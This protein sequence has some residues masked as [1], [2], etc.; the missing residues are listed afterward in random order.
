MFVWD[1]RNEVPLT[2]NKIIKKTNCIGFSS[3]ADYFVTVG[4]KTV[5]YWHF[6]PSGKPQVTRGSESAEFK[7]MASRS[8]ILSEM[9][10]KNFI[11][12]IVNSG[13]V[14]TLT[15]DGQL[16]IFTS[17]RTLDRWMDLQVAGAFSLS[18]SDNVLAC[19]CTEGVVRLFHADSLKYITSLPRPPPL[20]E[21]P[22]QSVPALNATTSFAD[23]VSVVLFNERLLTLY[24]DQSMLVWD[25]SQLGQIT[26]ARAFLHHSAAINDLKILPSSS[27][28]STQ[29]ITGSADKTLRLWSVCHTVPST[30]ET[31]GSVYSHDLSRIIYLSP[32]HEHFKARPGDCSSGGSVKCIS[33]SADGKSVASGDRA[34]MLRVHDVRTFKQVFSEQAHESDI[35]CMD[36]SG[37]YPADEETPGCKKFLATGSRDRLIHL[38]DVDRGYSCIST[39]DDHSSTVSDVKFMRVG[40]QERLVSSG[41]E[42]NLVFRTVTAAGASRDAQRTLKPNKC[43]SV[44]VHP[45]ESLIV[46]GEDKAVRV[47]DV[48]QAKVL[49]SYESDHSAKL[50]ADSNTKVVLDSSGLIVAAANTDRVLRLMDFNSG[51]VICRLSVGEVTTSMAFSPNGKTL[52]TSSDGCIFVWRLTGQPLET[53]FSGTSGLLARCRGGQM[54]LGGE[55]AEVTQKALLRMSM[56]AQKPFYQNAAEE[57][58]RGASEHDLKPRHSLLH[59]DS[60]MPDWAKSTLGKDGPKCPAESPFECIDQDVK[61][62]WGEAQLINLDSYEPQHE[63]D[64]II[65][66]GFNCID[67]GIKD[68]YSDEDD[69]AKSDTA[70][71]MHSCI[72]EACSIDRLSGVEEDQ[73]YEAELDSFDSLMKIDLSKSFIH[74]EEECKESSFE[75]PLLM[76]AGARVSFD[77]QSHS[78]EIG[79]DSGQKLDFGPR[80]ASLSVRPCPQQRSRQQYS[81]YLRSLRS[82]LHK[83]CDFFGRVD[84][85]DQEYNESIEESADDVDEI[86]SL[87]QDLSSKL[88]GASKEL[89]SR[90]EELLQRYSESLVTLVER[91]LLCCRGR[92]C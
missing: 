86:Q 90:D 54:G 71:W 57:L 29:F 7:A 26:A 46:T 85:D 38:F 67:L 14:F 9:K 88:G 82:N 47:W 63:E 75:L 21:A 56:R 43:Y 79:Q 92:D 68:A 44:A 20:G 69:E 2:S 64:A 45:L 10:E 40:G 22:D 87:L 1:W 4:V 70:A 3:D 30:V 11:S 15:S 72:E 61:S 23:A 66:S 58:R 81:Q 32:S 31:Q 18:L 35:L 17:E 25:I 48:E 73:G 8:V 41:H 37:H 5:K 52:L 12:V 62:R 91:K 42:K 49:K 84:P 39:I 19:A 55:V 28:D 65:L 78:L 74:R 36:Y 77:R 60:L 76:L 50:Q 80:Q 13:K 27:P 24:S 59:E 83:V 16:C 51:G 6:D 89:L 34:G 53:A 33:V